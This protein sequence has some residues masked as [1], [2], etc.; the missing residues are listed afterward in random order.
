MSS[1]CRYLEPT[2]SFVAFVP[3]LTPQ[4][5]VQAEYFI[6]TNGERLVRLERVERLEL[7]ALLRRLEP[8]AAIERLERA[9]VL[10][11]ARHRFS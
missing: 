6:L 10:F 2:Y 7:A 9:S 8:S 1:T 3:N 5:G 11:S 4:S